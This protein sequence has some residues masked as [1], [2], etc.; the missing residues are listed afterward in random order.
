MRSLAWSVCFILILAA[1]CSNDKPQFIKSFK[2]RSNV[3]GM[4]TDSVTTLISD[5]GRIR[6][7][8]LSEVWKVYDQA[9]EPYWFFPKKVYFERFDDSL[10]TESLVQSD[11]ATYYTRTKLWRLR[12]NVRMVNMKGEKFETSLLFWDQRGQRIYS[13]S[14]IRIEQQDQILTGYGFE[15]NEQLTRYHILK[16]TAVFPIDRDDTP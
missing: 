13:D 1:S 12:K 9:T 5:S 3:A 10:R 14:F 16:P 6:Y 11:T 2:E 15:S 4:Y 8:V 7:R